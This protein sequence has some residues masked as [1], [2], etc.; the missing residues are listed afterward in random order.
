MEQQE[1]GEGIPEEEQPPILGTW[2]RL[3]AFVL[4][5]LVLLILLF[6]LFTEVFS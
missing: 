2:P 5:E 6:Y 4:A 1:V 3:Y